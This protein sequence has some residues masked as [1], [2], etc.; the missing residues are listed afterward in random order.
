MEIT[1]RNFQRIKLYL[2]LCDAM[3]YR[4]QKY[5]C[6]LDLHLPEN[7]GNCLYLGKIVTLDWLVWQQGYNSMEICL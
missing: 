2:S 3:Q 5:Q 4:S 7:I 6:I 1:S